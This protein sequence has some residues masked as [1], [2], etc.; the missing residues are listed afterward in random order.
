MERAVGSGQGLVR[1]LALGC[2]LWG[3]RGLC[4]GASGTRVLDP[5][6]G[7]AVTSTTH[8]LTHCNSKF[9]QSGGRSLK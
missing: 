2:L 1:G 4:D 7:A 9:S 3:S 8:R 5:R 6:P